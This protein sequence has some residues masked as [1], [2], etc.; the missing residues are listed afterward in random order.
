[1]AHVSRG[2]LLGIVIF[3]LAEL[4]L[5][6]LMRWRVFRDDDIDASLETR[7]LSGCGGDEFVA[8]GGGILVQTLEFFGFSSAAAHTLGS[9]GTPCLS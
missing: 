3:G 4:S 8:E 7:R 6:V 2:R 1:M 5:L 9:Y